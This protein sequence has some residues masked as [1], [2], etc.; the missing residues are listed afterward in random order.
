MSEEENEGDRAVGV[1][2]VLRQVR[3]VGVCCGIFTIRVAS[4]AF[5]FSGCKPVFR[6]PAFAISAVQVEYQM[7][8]RVPGNSLFVNTSP[9]WLLCHSLTECL[10]RFFSALNT[11]TSKGCRIWEACAGKQYRIM[12]FVL[13]KDAASKDK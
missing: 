6:N 9:G 2:A 12:P 3:L 1:A 10:H 11:P 4:Y 13:A 8:F 7:L 5:G